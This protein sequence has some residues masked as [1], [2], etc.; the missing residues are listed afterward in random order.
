MKITIEW[1]QEKQASEEK[2]KWFLAQ[3][4]ID[5]IKLLHKLR[6]EKNWSYFLWLAPKFMT[7]IQIAEWVVYAAEQA[8][9]DFEKEFPDDKRPRQAIEAT[10]KLVEEVLENN[11]DIGKT[12]VDSTP[13]LAVYAESAEAVAAYVAASGDD[14]ILDRILNKALEILTQK[15]K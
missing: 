15:T 5:A 6:E 1:L 9:P 8:L 2:I 12:Y 14:K 3:D 10:K 4:E 13:A 11:N 7:Q